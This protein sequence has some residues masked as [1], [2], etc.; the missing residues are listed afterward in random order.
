MAAELQRQ[1][2][3]PETALDVPAPSPTA[4]LAAELRIPAG[5]HRRVGR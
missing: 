2:D 3:L 5:P 1:L 4:R